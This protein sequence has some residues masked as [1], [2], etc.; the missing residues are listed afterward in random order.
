[1][2]LGRA[3][4]LQNVI[5][6][7]G[8]AVGG[9]T[10]IA[11]GL[12]KWASKTKESCVTTEGMDAETV[13]TI[14]GVV[15]LLRRAAEMSWLQAEVEGPRSSRQLLALGIDAAAD[16]GSALVP[17]RVRLDQPTP[18]GEDPAELLRSAEQL[19]RQIC[20][21]DAPTHVASL[22]TRVAALVR[23]ADTG[24]A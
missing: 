3:Y 24:A 9:L 2:V 8:V 5:L 15:R 13:E 14:A 10:R 21:E 1:V 18:V 4:G 6:S 16:D 23:E 20:A 19:L 17:R 11:Y 12:I 7:T 22:S